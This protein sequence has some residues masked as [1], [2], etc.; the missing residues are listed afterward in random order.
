MVIKVRRVKSEI[1]KQVTMYQLA[2]NSLSE[3]RYSK[4][5][6]IKTA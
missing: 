4:L 2:W 1:V 3:V 6:I 5:H